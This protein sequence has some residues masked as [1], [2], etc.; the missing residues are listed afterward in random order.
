MDSRKM[1]AAEIMEISLD[2]FLIKIKKGL[3]FAGPFYL[4]SSRKVSSIK[5]GLVFASPFYF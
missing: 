4:V 2:N 3:V 1:K 5:K